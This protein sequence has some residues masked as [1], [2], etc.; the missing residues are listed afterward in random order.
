V[1]L[2]APD[3]LDRVDELFLAVFVLADLPLAAGPFLAL[4]LADLRVAAIVLSNVG[5]QIRCVGAVTDARGS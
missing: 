1:A 3:F 2:G 5:D 4:R